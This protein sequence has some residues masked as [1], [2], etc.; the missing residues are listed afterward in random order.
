MVKSLVREHIRILLMDFNHMDKEERMK[1]LIELIPD[2]ELMY[3]FDHNQPAHCYDVFEHTLAVVDKMP[4]DET[5]RLAALLHDIGKPLK[6][7][8]TDD[9][10]SHYWGHPMLSYAMSERI[11]REL[12][13]GED[14]VK[15]VSNLCL[16]HDSY[17]DSSYLEFITVASQIGFSNIDRLMMLQRADLHSHA[18]WYSEKHEMQLNES[19]EHIREFMR[20]AHEENYY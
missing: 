1:G 14:I 17:I 2:L 18:A 4:Y 15:T 5:S 16:Y 13:Y 7:V 12:D 19:H 6:M 9:G 20:K 11:L 8:K 3:H 10:V